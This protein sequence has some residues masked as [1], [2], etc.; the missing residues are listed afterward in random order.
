MPVF[1]SDAL[2]ALFDADHPHHAEAKRQFEGADHVLVHPSVVTEFTTVV[3]RHAKA[4]GLDGNVAAREAL[5]DVLE[6]PRVRIEERLVYP[7]AVARYMESNTLS[8]T[9]AIVAQLAW[10][11][12]NPPVTFD[13]QLRRAGT[14]PP[15]GN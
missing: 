15:P 6:Q 7:A 1:D 11:D 10:Q 5:G 2:V 4:K 12:Q 9:D 14:Q 8:F 13:G 3:R